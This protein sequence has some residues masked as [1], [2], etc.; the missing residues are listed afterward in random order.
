MSKG[1]QVGV[2]PSRRQSPARRG[3]VTADS[4]KGPRRVAEVADR[5]LRPCKEG[6]QM[7]AGPVV[8]PGLGSFDVVLLVEVNSQP[9]PAWSEMPAAR[10]GASEALVNSQTLDGPGRIRC[11][12]LGWKG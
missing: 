7:D 11:A 6:L 1:E 3:S 9:L 2:A 10:P 5:T 12:I 4:Q 8:C